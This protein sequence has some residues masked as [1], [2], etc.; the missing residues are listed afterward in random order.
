MQTSFTVDSPNNTPVDGTRPVPGFDI[1]Q[2]L[3]FRPPRYYCEKCLALCIVP[4]EPAI[5]SAPR[6]G[7]TVCH[8]CG[9]RYEPTESY[10]R[11]ELAR[12]LEQQG[13]TLLFRDPVGHAQ[14]LATVARQIRANSG[15]YP[16]MR[17]FYDLLGAAEQFIHFAT[18]NISHI[19]IGALKLASN[20]VTIRGIVG[21]TDPNTANELTE[22]N[23]ESPRFLVK[24]CSTSEASDNIVHQKLVVID[25]LLAL[26]GS[27]N[28]TQ[29]A[30]RKVLDGRDALEPATDINEVMTLHNRLFS[31]HWAR[32][33]DV[34]DSILMDDGVPF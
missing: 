5:S 24:V 30:W 11:W 16:P 28:L 20:R 18:Y 25:G 3:A 26:K 12:Y 33:S 1:E 27:A 31:V 8:V 2:L 22:Y 10:N 14:R 7:P 13:C 9:V 4:K 6:I 29:A 19:M 23:N 34:G 32:M 15:S 21:V 17:C